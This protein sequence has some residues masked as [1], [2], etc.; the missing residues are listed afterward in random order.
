MSFGPE[1]FLVPQ[2][3]ATPDFSP[4]NYT[5]GEIF[6]IISS[7]IYGLIELYLNPATTTK[8][9]YCPH[10]V[11]EGESAHLRSNMGSIPIITPAM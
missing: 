6:T 2:Q 7:K 1:S 3:K 10:S 9:G 5:A 8:L 4:F 11:S